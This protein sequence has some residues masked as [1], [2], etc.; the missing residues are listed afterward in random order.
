MSNTIL[1]KRSTVAN[2][3]PA[4]NTVAPGELAINIQDGN[5][6]YKNAANVVTVIASNQFVSVTGNVTGAFI[7]GDG[8]GL[9]NV[10]SLENGT[11]DVSI[12]SANANVVV[13][14][15]GVANTVIIG[16]GSLFVQGPISTPKT[17]NTFATVA[18]NTNSVM[19]SP[20]TIEASGNIVIPDSSTLVIFNAGFTSYVDGGAA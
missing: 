16:P 12:S 17:F 15:A 10:R 9:S 4:A 19:F 6:F 13:D 1:L 18:D 14:V 20:L 7:N 2:S 5:L 3:V 11:S 8:R